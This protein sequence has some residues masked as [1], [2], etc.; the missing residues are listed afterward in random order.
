MS[1]KIKSVIIYGIFFSYALCGIPIIW[2]AMVMAI[3]YRM[4]ED[5]HKFWETDNIVYGTECVYLYDKTK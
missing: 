1:F 5:S 3:I 2:A 4:Y